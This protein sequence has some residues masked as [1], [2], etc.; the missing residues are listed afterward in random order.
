[1]ARR[2]GEKERLRRSEFRR[3]GRLFRAREREGHFGFEGLRLHVCVCRSQH[4]IFDFSFFGQ[5]CG[6][7]MPLYSCANVSC[8]SSICLQTVKPYTSTLKSRQ[9]FIIVTKSFINRWRNQKYN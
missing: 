2:R 8:L 7:R 9:E 3:K 4:S 5:A 6:R 1:M